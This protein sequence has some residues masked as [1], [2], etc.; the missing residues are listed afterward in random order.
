MWREVFISVR[1]REAVISSRTMKER[2]R[3][4]QLV[5]ARWR[6]LVR[7]EERRRK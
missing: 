1:K 3:H 6:P 7:Q 4:P 2:R 5:L